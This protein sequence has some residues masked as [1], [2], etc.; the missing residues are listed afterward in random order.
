MI[1]S[2]AWSAAGLGVPLL[3]ALAFIPLLLSSIGE[4]RF[5]AFSLGIAL[6]SFSGL[7]DLGIGRAT[8]R[9]ISSLLGT[10]RRQ[11][12]MSTIA[13]ARALSVK[14]GVGGSCLLL[15]VIWMGTPDLLNY[16]SDSNEELYF[17]AT[18]VALLV[19]V[20]T[21]SALF[22]GVCE[23]H[24]AFKGISIV[25]MISGVLLLGLPA[26]VSLVSKDLVSLMLAVAATRL[27]SLFAYDRL[28]RLHVYSVTTSFQN[29][30][31]DD[32]SHLPNRDLKPSL[33][34][35]GAWATVSNVLNPLMAVSDRF[36]IG[37]MISVAAVAA[38]TIP[39]DLVI[40]LLVI[41]GAITTVLFPR[42]TAMASSGKVGYERTFL[43]W[44]LLVAILM[45]TVS[46]ATYLLIPLALD[47][48]LSSKVPEGSIYVARILVIGLL[49]YAIGTMFVALA[50]AHD[51]P[52]VTAKSHILQAP[53]YFAVAYYAISAFGIHGAAYTWVIRV[54]ADAAILVA[55]YF[56]WERR[57]NLV[58]SRIAPE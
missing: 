41:P 15:A 43:A 39:Y 47:T 22:R 30:V 57:K 23:A 3:A 10:N 20:Q 27:L 29:R 58:G 40:Q 4:A 35:F 52:D 21:I 8:T 19:P 11:H 26:L 33:V 36:M 38:Y 51:R 46:V 25:R 6:L 50:H 5:G 1:A 44:M 31:E 17:A 16:P 18:I 7:F 12:I 37:S 9:S 55:W 48:W 49:P 32:S 28:S 45:L 56:G 53:I 54:T 14:Y 42:L 2:I 24:A 34:R 13:A